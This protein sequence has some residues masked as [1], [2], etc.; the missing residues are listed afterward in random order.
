[1]SKEHLTSMSSNTANSKPAERPT[2]LSP[3]KSKGKQSQVV[4][5]LVKSLEEENIPLGDE[6]GYG[7]HDDDEDYGL[8]GYTSPLKDAP[9]YHTYLTL[10]PEY[11]EEPEDEP[12][13]SPD[14]APLYDNSGA[15]TP[16]SDLPSPTASEIEQNEAEREV[17][18]NELTEVESDIMALRQTL[19]SKEVRAKE[20]RRK[21]GMTPIHRIKEDVSTGWNKL[22]TSTA[23]QNTSAKMSEWNEYIT[24]SETYSKTKTGLSSA[25][26]KTTA[27]FSTFGSVVTRKLGEVRDSNAFKSFEEKISTATANVKNKVGRSQSQDSSFEDVLQSTASAEAKN[28]SSSRPSDPPLPEEKVPL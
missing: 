23:Y 1:M 16:I 7:S 25:G 5:E 15:T 8:D 2:K 9:S 4:N 12:L 3:S 20:I 22:Q 13:S 21:L 24:T 26:Q 14:S 27:A 18:F 19:R 28:D 17:L 6:E 10:V 11:E